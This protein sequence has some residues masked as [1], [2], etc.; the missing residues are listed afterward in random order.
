MGR[1]SSPGS[2]PPSAGASA[3]APSD[4]LVGWALVVMF[5]VMAFFA[6]L[7]FGPADPFA[8]AVPTRRRPGPEPAAAEPRPGAVPPADPVPRLRRL[9]GAVRVRHRRAHHRPRRRGLADGD[10]ALGAVRVGVP[11]DR[12][13]ARRVVELRGARLERRVGLGPGRER[14]LPAVADRHRLHPLGARPGAPRDAARLEPQPARRHVR[15][16]DPRHVPHPLRA[17]S[18]ASTPSATGRSATTCWRSSG[19]SSSCRCCSSAGAATACG[20]P[21]RSTRRCRARAPS[22][23]TTCCSRCSRSSSCSA[24]CSRCSSRRCRTAGPSSGRRTSTACRCRSG[25]RLLFLMAIAPVLPW[26]KASGELLRDRLFWPAWGGALGDRRRR[27][28]RRHRPVVAAGV[29]PRRLRR[30]RRRCARS[31]WRRAARAGGAS[32]GGPTAG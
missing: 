23:P 17:C 26:R 22:S 14:Q 6:L 27:A 29:R 9:H 24:P 4:P 18:T 8:S 25:S 13:P 30:R 16:D 1:R 10:P 21:A 7:S 19:S 11:D 2:R 3:S 12:H 32:S 28:R 15:A 31:C 5:V 20:R